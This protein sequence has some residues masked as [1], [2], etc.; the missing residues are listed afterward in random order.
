MVWKRDSVGCGRCWLAHLVWRLRWMP[1][2]EQIQHLQTKLAG[3]RDG[4]Y[5]GKIIHGLG[6]KAHQKKVRAA[7]TGA[8]GASPNV[9]GVTVS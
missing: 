5:V 3:K 7:G 9:S 6:E 4:F 1:V 2:Q 8:G